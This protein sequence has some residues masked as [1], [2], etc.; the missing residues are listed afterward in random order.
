[1]A[2]RLA[3]RNGYP[4]DFSQITLR[5]HVLGQPCSW[6]LPRRIFVCS[7]GDLFHWD[8]RPDWRASV[9]NVMAHCPQH[10]FM[11]LTKRPENIPDG[12]VFPPNVWLGTTAE[13]QEMADKRI[14]MMPK[15]KASVRFL[16]LEPL[17]GP[18]DLSRW[19]G[20]LVIVG[21]ETGPGARPM[22]PD[23]VRSIRDQCQ[24]AG[25]PFFFKGWGEWGQCPYCKKGEYCVTCDSTKMVRVGRRAA[26]RLLDGREHNEFPS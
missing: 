13:N 2:K 20:G 17:L 8:V 24:A 5:Q 15:V 4:E 9:F 23:W 14:Q 19:I 1:M 10:T 7:M 22:H 11:V 25:V 3:G 12:L 6:K 18:V 16:S 26:G 21:G